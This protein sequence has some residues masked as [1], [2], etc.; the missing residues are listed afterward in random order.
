MDNILANQAFTLISG[1]GYD[2][3]SLA[4][5]V[6]ERLRELIMEGK[7]PPGSQLPNEP[8]LSALLKVSRS[9]V[10]SALTILEQG[11][12]VIRH[13]GVG[14]FIS[15]NP[16][17][18]NNLSL[19]SGVTQLIRSSGAE[20]GFVELLMSVRPANERVAS[21]LNLELGDS[22]VVFERVRLANDRRVVFSIDIIPHL[23]FQ[24]FGNGISL[25][26]VEQFLH[27]EQSMYTFLHERLGL[28]IHHGIARIRP[29]RAE[30]YISDKLE[31]PPGSSILHIEQVDFG[32][33]GE[34]VALTDEYYDPEAFTFYI[35]RSN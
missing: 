19:N 11:G 10:R 34:P 17:T 13:W 24:N 22:V 14:T 8:D 35:Y 23:I 6:S 2:N 16:P 26:E 27:D 5:R 28:G 21:L 25:D 4:Q 9:T 18:Y 30:A 32:N 29:L 33:D 15:K 20:P 31:I 1:D 12:F 7:L 3:S